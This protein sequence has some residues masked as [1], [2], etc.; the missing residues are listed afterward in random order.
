M[1]SKITKT[2]TLAD[3]SANAQQNP[4]PFTV[5]PK[6]SQ[7]IRD[8]IETASKAQ[9]KFFSNDNIAAFMEP[10]DDQK[11]IDEV[12]ENMEAVLDSLV[13]DREKDHNTQDTARRVAK[14]FVNEMFAGRYTPAPKT[15]VFPNDKNLDQMYVVGPIT[16]N[17][18]CAHHLVPITGK[19]WVGVLAGK[20]VLGLSKYHRLVQWCA[21]R[22]QIQEELTMQIGDLL[23][24]LVEPRGIAVLIEATHMCCAIRGVKDADSKMITSEVR[25][26]MRD[27]ASVKD[28]FFRNVA[29]TR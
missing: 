14:M 29:M 4:I 13:I 11:M 1:T 21:S 19:A 16:L 25:G 9:Q 8:R 5:K 10:G 27:S 24:T 17:S 2:V 7:V 18:C 12:A 28:E 20:N 15:T 22:P 23:E 26:L 6:I 3:T